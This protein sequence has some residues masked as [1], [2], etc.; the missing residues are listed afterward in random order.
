MSDTALI[1]RSQI[2]SLEALSS[3]EKIILKKEEAVISKGLST[4]RDVGEALVAIRD[5]RLY[6][7]DFSSFEAYCRGKWGISK[8]QANRQIAAAKVAENLAPIGLIPANESVVRPLT[9]LNADQQ[10]VVWE[11]L[12]KSVDDGQEKRPITAN[13]VTRAINEVIP[14]RR[15]AAALASKGRQEAAVDLIRRSET[16]EAID[17]FVAGHPKLGGSA[18]RAIAEVRKLIMAL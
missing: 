11:K 16:L 7:E 6:R 8:T 17:T 13:L 5:R 3:E 9:S 4:F 1:T 15:K 18:K 10:R 2:H 12:T 14:H